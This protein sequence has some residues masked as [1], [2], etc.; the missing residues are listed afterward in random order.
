MM[1]GGLENVQKAIEYFQSGLARD[2][3]NALEIGHQ[4]LI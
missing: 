4:G 1:R 3:D 2:P